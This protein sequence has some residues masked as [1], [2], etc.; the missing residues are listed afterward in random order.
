MV[1]PKIYSDRRKLRFGFTFIE[2]LVVLAMLAIIA[3]ITL[4]FSLNFYQREL[5]ASERSL[6]ISIL[7]TARAKAMQ[8]VAGMPHGVAINPANTHQY[9]VFVADS[10]EK[11]E[12]STSLIIPYSPNIQFASSTPET[13]IFSQL[14]GQANYEGMIIL[15]GGFLSGSSTIITINYEGAIY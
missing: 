5:L 7:Q 1:L 9:V 3:S 2:V 15:K 6:L 12:K 11:A 8:N 13:I 4:F 14:S 10:Y